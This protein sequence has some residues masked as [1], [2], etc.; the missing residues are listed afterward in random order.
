MKKM[1]T[2]H[3]IGH[4]GRRVG[5][6]VHYR[7]VQSYHCIGPQLGYLFPCTQHKAT[8]NSLS[9]LRQFLTNNNDCVF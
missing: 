7:C 9:V 3:S 1:F 6:F 8:Q 2:L 4:T 5:S